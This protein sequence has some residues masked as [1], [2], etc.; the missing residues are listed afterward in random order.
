MFTSLRSRLWL[1]YA[2]VI[3]IALSTVVIVLFAF[4]IR[5][6][7]IARQVQERLRTAQSAILADSQKFVDD[8]NALKDIT[9]TYNVRVLVFNSVRQ[10][11][12]DSNP[13][14]AR[15]P[16]PRRNLFARSTQIARDTNGKV[17]LY[18]FKRLSQDRILVVAA[19]RPLVPAL[20]IFTDELLVPILEG[21]LIALMLSLVL[22]FAL[23]RW[24]ADPLQ[25]LVLAAR[26]Y[27]A[28]EL[29]PVPVRGPHEVQDLTHAF[30]SMVGR[31]QDSKKSQ[32]DFVANVSHELKTPLTSIQGFAQAILDDTADTPETRKQSAQIIY[33]EAGR[34]HRMALDL[35][36]LARLEAGT[37]D[38]KMSPVDIGVLLRNV[39]EKFAPQAQRAGV[40]LQ[41][42]L[43][44]QLPTLMGDGDRLAQVFV[45]LVDNALKFTPVNGQVTLS[46]VQ[47]GSQMEISII[48]TGRGVP[49]D[50]LPHLFERFYQVDPARSG[51]EKHGAGLG[52]AIVQ[53]IVQAHSGRI[54]V[55]SG[56]GHGTTFVIHLPLTQ[57]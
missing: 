57:K 39:L 30:N 10:L 47:T 2:F 7:L 49:Q 24:V 17:W 51:G 34:M 22:A 37:A 45:N 21:G 6:P 25:Q 41:L 53:E 4:L 16:F 33:E 46:A 54:S 18:T 8:P 3:T 19:P 42:D 1:S 15:L 55:R 5:N 11:V 31:V 27:P 20:N 56:L 52:L 35:L 40:N 13:Q 50:A 43:P 44:E 9:Q 32:R 48:D 12:F 38:L 23:S 14:S 36:D 26:N 29:S 28:E